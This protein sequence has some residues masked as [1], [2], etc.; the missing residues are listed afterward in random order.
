MSKTKPNTVIAPRGRPLLYTQALAE[1]ICA[2]LAEGESLR[3]ICIDEMPHES[4]VRL[5]VADD[6]QGFAT[7]YARSRAV[8][9]ERHAEE[10]IDLADMC[11]MG[12]KTT[13]KADGT[14]EVVTSDMVDRA[15]LQID[16][17]KWILAKMLPKKYGDKIAIGGADDLPAIKAQTDMSDAALLAIATKVVLIGGNDPTSSRN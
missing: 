3:S 10:I 5:W 11:R 4:T 2:R 7:H 15:R 6:V 9:Y 12:A 17:R 13:T 16:A 14:T 8:G 1:T